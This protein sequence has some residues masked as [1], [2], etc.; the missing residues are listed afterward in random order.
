MKLRVARCVALFLPST[1]LGDEPC[2]SLSAFGDSQS[3]VYERHGQE[4]PLYVGESDERVWFRLTNHTTCPILIPA[5]YLHPRTLPDGRLTFDPADGVEIGLGVHITYPELG[6]ERVYRGVPG[7][8][9]LP[10]G[11]SVVFSVAANL[12][13]RG[14]IAVDLRYEWERPSAGCG[15]I[16]HR[17]VFDP[18]ELFRDE[19]A[20]RAWLAKVN[21]PPKPPRPPAPVPDG[22]P[23]AVVERHYPPQYLTYERRGVQHSGYINESGERV[24]FRFHNNATCSVM[25][26]AVVPF[27]PDGDPPNPYVPLEAL[28]VWVAEPGQGGMRLHW[29]GIQGF[30][31]PLAPGQSVVFSV[32]A[33]LVKRGPIAIAFTYAWETS[34]GSPLVGMVEHRLTFDIKELLEGDPELEEWLKDVKEPA[35][36][37]PDVNDKSREGS[38]MAAPE[39]E[40]RQPGYQR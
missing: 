39:N 19:P 8:S 23:C 5:P 29:G 36:R 27:R 21:D 28:N 3:V 25:L 1:L 18:K 10:A 12:V 20:L 33:N 15:S 38:S 24:W 34:A 35:P 16:E 6:G 30:P 40:I 32:A 9:R 26:P 37:E 7:E 11:Q 17:L 4:R 14:P 2:R 31:S 22:G 13:K